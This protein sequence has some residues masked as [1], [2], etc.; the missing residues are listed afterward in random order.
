MGLFSATIKRVSVSLLRFPIIIIII[1]IKK[2]GS[3]TE[4]A[5]KRFTKL[6]LKSK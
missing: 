2:H 4:L 3:Q 5:D 1:I 6:V